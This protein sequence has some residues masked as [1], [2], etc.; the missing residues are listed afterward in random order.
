MEQAT[1]ASDGTL[2]AALSLWDTYRALHPLMTIFQPEKQK[3]FVEPSGGKYVFG[4]PLL[5]KATIHVGEGKTFTVRTI[6]NSEENIYIQSATLNGKPY[7][8][9]Y[10]HYADIMKGG[11]LE[12][13]M[14]SKP[15]AFGT[16][17][18]DRP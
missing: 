8:R 12:F 4:S 11:T 6:G 14:G 17:K 18:A 9:S 16:K 7:T 2:L 10:I 5:D 15:S 1:L 13:V 3:D